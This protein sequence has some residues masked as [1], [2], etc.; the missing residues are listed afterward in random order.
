M[1]KRKADDELSKNKRK[2]RKASKKAGTK[3]DQEDNKFD[4]M[5]TQGISNA[6]LERIITGLSNEVKKETNFTMIS[7][8]KTVQIQSQL[9][10][11]TQQ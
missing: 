8:S 11:Q 9:Q 6:E 7:L 5:E 4:A 1:K 3:E 10:A 2:K